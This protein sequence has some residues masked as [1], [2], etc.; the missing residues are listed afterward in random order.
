MVKQR[1]A[2]SGLEHLALD[3]HGA[4]FSPKRIIDQINSCLE[5]VKLSSA[6]DSHLDHQRLKEL[7]EKLNKH[8][9]ELHKQRTPSGLSIYQL[10]GKVL[11][12]PVEARLDSRWNT[13]K[14]KE[15]T[16]EVL[17]RLNSLL[18]D[19]SGFEDFFL[20]TSSSNWNGAKI[21]DGYIAD[22]VLSLSKTIF[23]SAIPNLERVIQ[24]S[25]NKTTLIIPTAITNLEKMLAVVQGCN[26]ILESYKP[27]FFQIDFDEI[28][29]S[30]KSTQNMFS[31]IWHYF[32]DDRY[33][34]SRKLIIGLRTKTKFFGTNIF[35]DLK[36]TKKLLEEWRNISNKK[37][38]YPMQQIDIGEIWRCLR[39]SKN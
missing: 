14:L 21:K 12:I 34:K 29:I 13:Q 28:A 33:R 23:Q 8:V 24:K 4:D 18:V 5:N 39:I 3:F 36:Q 31:A 11:I 32:T 9:Q 26:A 17:Q 1:L 16:P 22:D 35:K 30:I 27:G 37:N 15:I 2:R 7:R 38:S 19:A 6:I 25:F 10:Q 20:R